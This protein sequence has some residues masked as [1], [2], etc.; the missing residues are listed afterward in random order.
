MMVGFIFIVN[1]LIQG[2]NEKLFSERIGGTGIVNTQAFSK[3]SE[4][5]V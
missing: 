4:A 3:R 1:G 2:N 5:V